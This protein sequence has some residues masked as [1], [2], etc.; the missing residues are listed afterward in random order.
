VLVRKQNEGAYQCPTCRYRTGDISPW[1]GK[2][3]EVIGPAKMSTECP[4][5]RQRHLTPENFWN[6]TIR[7]PISNLHFSVHESW[8]EEDGGAPVVARMVPN[9]NPPLSGQ[10]E[11]VSGA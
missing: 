11:A 9:W 2:V 1:L 10:A 6:L 3:V 7:S 8:L 5:C 4:K